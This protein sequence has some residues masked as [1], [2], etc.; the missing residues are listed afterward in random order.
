MN[1]NLRIRTLFATINQCLV[2]ANKLIDELRQ[3]EHN[4]LILWFL[5]MNF[6]EKL[7][8]FLSDLIQLVLCFLL[9]PFHIENSLLQEL[10]QIR[11]VVL[12]LLSFATKCWPRNIGIWSSILGCAFR[13]F[14]FCCLLTFL[15]FFFKHFD[16][17]F[18]LVDD[19]I[20][21]VW[22]LGQLLLNFTML[23]QFNSEKLHLLSHFVILVRQLLCMLWLI[24]Q[25]TR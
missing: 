4:I 21:E 22:S 15:Y 8:V 24:L 6:L 1:I 5:L 19:T 23:F 25:L 14:S 20:A 13:S 17:C 18:V 16:L 10:S 7:F 3:Q 2:F 11:L 9:F 12:W